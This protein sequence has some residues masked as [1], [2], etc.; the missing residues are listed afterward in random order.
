VLTARN[1]VSAFKLQ[2]CITPSAS[3]ITTQPDACLRDV[4]G[5]VKP[6]HYH[7]L[8]DENAFGADA[9]Q[10]AT[11]WL[12]YAF[13]RCTRSVS[14]CPPAYYAH[15]VADRGRVLLDRE[16]RFLLDFDDDSVLVMLA[17]AVLNAHRR[18]PWPCAA[19]ARDAHNLRT[20][21]A[22][23]LLLLSLCTCALWWMAAACCPH[24]V[25]QTIRVQASMKRLDVNTSLIVLLRL[26]TL[27]KCVSK[28]GVEEEQRYTLTS[29]RGTQPCVV[30]VQRCTCAAAVLPRCRKMRL[31][32]FRSRAYV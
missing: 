18:E 3:I 22:S 29:P 24:A 12:C 26:G 16:A 21:V 15:L 5:T 2:T 28:I 9:I 6:A 25:R 32:R 7:V 17:Y 8:H 20:A 10:I 14:Y 13:C 23:S 11:Y 27:L 4:Q 1:A 19:R 30:P 31:A